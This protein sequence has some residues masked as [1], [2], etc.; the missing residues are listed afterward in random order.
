MDPNLPPIPPKSASQLIK[1]QLNIPPSSRSKNRILAPQ[2]EG[3]SVSALPWNS[4]RNE[5]R[6]S[7]RLLAATHAW[8]HAHDF[9]PPWCIKE[10][11]E[12]RRVSRQREEEIRQRFVNEKL[13]KTEGR[14]RERE[15]GERLSRPSA[16]SWNRYR[17]RARTRE[18]EKESGRTTKR[19]RS[20][21]WSTERGER[22]TERADRGSWLRDEDGTRQAKER[23]CALE[24]EVRE[25]GREREMTTGRVRARATGSTRCT[26]RACVRGE[27]GERTG[28]SLSTGAKYSLSHRREAT[29]LSRRG[30]CSRSQ[31]QARVDLS[32]SWRVFGQRASTQRFQTS[33]RVVV[34]HEVRDRHTSVLGDSTN[35]DV[36]DLAAERSG[37]RGVRRF[38]FDSEEEGGEGFGEGG[39]GRMPGFD[40]GRRRRMNRGCVIN[41]WPIEWVTLDRCIVFGI[42]WRRIISWKLFCPV[43]VG[44]ITPKRGSV[45]KNLGRINV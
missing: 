29:R 44:N 1:S 16:A 34:G 35:G 37:W 19:S 24:R 10:R 26:H 36:N 32:L 15:T 17:D 20:G 30:F 12:E 6:I 31:I 14:N 9:M 38:G 42:P 21:G 7:V 18:R 43:L 40:V 39:C 3:S 45:G 8:L 41:L 4:Q 25:G 13:V 27:R 22:G 5:S 23:G 2:A 28:G 11:R 33:G